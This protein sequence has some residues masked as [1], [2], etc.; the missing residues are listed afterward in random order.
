MSH[1]CIIF[2]G[3]VVNAR[4][5]TPTYQ[6]TKMYI[7]IAIVLWESWTKNT[8]LFQNESVHNR[9][10]K[11]FAVRYHRIFS[12]FDHLRAESKWSIDLDSL[13]AYL[14]QVGK[15]HRPCLLTCARSGKASPC[16]L[17]C[18][19]SSKT[20]PAC[21]P[22]PGRQRHRQAGAACWPRGRSVTREHGPDAAPASTC[23]ECHA[24]T[25]WTSPALRTLQWL[26]DVHQILQAKTKLERYIFILNECI[27][28]GVE[29]VENE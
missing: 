11:N 4:L 19:R 22:A 16:L 24:A 13:P 28:G 14:R 20:P 3:R 12:V 23:A 26:S 18:T 6:W 9:E 5:I 7:C 8:L 25:R 17:T 29:S 15:R 10:F 2:E 27:S 1:L 21:L